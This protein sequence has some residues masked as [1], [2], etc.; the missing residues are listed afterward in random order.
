MEKIRDKKSFVHLHVHSEYSLLD[1]ACRIDRLVEKAADLGQ[2][3]ISI[4]DHG[5]MCGAVEFYSKAKSAGIKP[6]IG[7]EVYVAPRTRHDK[8]QRFDSKP[9]H[10]VLLCKNN[11][12]YRNLIK[13]VSAGFTEGF[14]SK[15]RVDEEL[16]RKY[17]G[18]LICLSAC[19]AGEIPRRLSENN[20]EEALKT[21][22]RYKNIF[23]DGNFYIEIQDHGI[24]EQ[25]R[26]LPGLCRISKEA[27]IPLAAT[28]DVHYIEKSDAEIQNILLCIQIKKTIY[29]PNPMKFPTEE[30]YLKSTEEMYSL[31]PGLPEAVAN[32]SEIAE[33]CNVEL[34]FG[35][36]RLPEFKIDGVADN[37]I[38]F[39]KICF[40]GLHRK[41]GEY[42]A[43]E[44][45]ERMNYELNVISGMGYVDYFLI[46]WDFVKYAKDNG[47]P[48]GPGRGSGA[49]SI[50]AYCIGITDI[51]PVKYNLLFE[52]FLNPERV[53]MP[54][55]DIDFCIEGRQQ[56]IDYVVRRYGE[57]RVSQIIA[58]DTLKAR[59]AVRD[60]GRVIGL[61]NK[62]RNDIAVMIPKEL[63]ITISQAIDK[64][65]D[66]K[67]I[68]SSNHSAR[69]LL[70][71]AMR[72]EGMPRNDTVHAAGVVI[73]SS[74]ITDLVPVKLSG[75]SV[76][77]QYTAVSLESLG[78]LKM[79]FL[80]LRNLTLIRNCVNE[81]HKTDPSFDIDNI[82]IEDKAVFEM[83]ADGKTTGVFQFES[84]GMRRVLNKLRPENLEDLIAVI[85]LYRPGPSE[86]IPKY[87]ENKH[88][89]ENISYKHPLLKPILEV[90]Y[91]CIVYQE[92]VMEICRALAGYSYGRA[93]LVRRA[94]AKKKHDVMQKERSSFVYGDENPNGKNICCGAVAKG[95]S[96][97][98]ANE[99]FDEMSGF[100]SYAFNK[101]HAAAY[102]Y[103]SYQTAYLKCHY[104]RE[105]MAALMSSV[106]GSTDKLA[107]YVEECR[108]NGVEI[109]RPDINRSSWDFRVE[110]GNIRYGLLA[111]KSL[112]LGV[113]KEII[114][115]RSNNGEY[116]S[117]QNFCERTSNISLSRM[118]VE[119]LI[120]AGA[121]DG[122]GAN[123]RQMVKNYEYL[124]DCAHDHSKRN[125]EGQLD[126][127]S[128]QP[129]NR[130][131]EFRFK[132]EEEYRYADILCFE[133]YATGMYISGHP[134]EPYMNYIRLMKISDSAMLTEA[135]E[136]RNLQKNSDVK[137]VGSVDDISVKYTSTGKKMAFVNLQDKCGSMNIILFPDVY[138][139][140]EKTL[141]YGS[142]ICVIGKIS[143]R[144]AA[145]FA[146]ICDN[147]LDSE[148][149][150]HLVSLKRLCIKINASEKDKF[151]R[152]NNILKKF[153][154][155]CKVC[156]YI[157]DR[158]AFVR[159]RNLSGINLND[160]FVKCLIC[161]TGYDGIG[162]ID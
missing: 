7:C 146:I 74:D 36:I 105:Y 161:E 123:R 156:F 89:P 95:V 66:L 86:S 72:V 152:I 113:I 94:M 57:E 157:T 37:E 61:D 53:S 155:K 102:A 24:E 159:P 34:E 3:A 151:E 21:A 31:F 26:I 116:Y 49:G 101:S 9:Y 111:V 87:I 48:V 122:L 124:M 154:G 104:F 129:E 65:P 140:Y 54:D 23:G 2:T 108:L 142:V 47:I 127:F 90:T 30:F 4:T 79:D 115:E 56:V 126:L 121:F 10:L 18:G 38:F 25:K 16:L 75:N 28:N 132:P 50:C 120:K 92:Q 118:S 78:L 76:V 106:V 91:G 77:T 88:N 100:A 62:F 114:C 141:E 33:K 109:L 145:D 133:K 11:E 39:R 20:Y 117:L 60:V 143:V 35:V 138:K 32:T 52:R 68:Y 43:D 110:N 59:A 5:V 134:L 80:G 136:N 58:F 103:L 22:I 131:T 96:E 82:P 85:S 93:D 73:S 135:F 149:F 17:S 112:G 55:F 46:V 69:R 29:E 84:A 128:E 64:N 67:E 42:P 119:H 150:L 44:I 144:S 71:L 15:P 63:N 12:G 160:E 153:P 1:G 83:M 6:I 147:I 137:F 70:D 14:Y 162:L 19:L 81:I 27:D 158:K 97:Q 40:D 107:E 51:D 139:K 130:S 98:T 125:I 41:Y 45:T 8:D 13:L 99:I 148:E